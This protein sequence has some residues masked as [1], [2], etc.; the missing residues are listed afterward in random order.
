L[1]KRK[2]GK[3]TKPSRPKYIARNAN[4]HFISNF[5]NFLKKKPA[6][7]HKNIRKL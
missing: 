4:D 6:E 3:K 7:N 5:G 2:I 1:K